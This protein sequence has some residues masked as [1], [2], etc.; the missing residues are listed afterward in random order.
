MVDRRIAR[1]DVA[2]GRGSPRFELA[3]SGILSHLRKPPRGTKP[4]R[5]PTRR[6]NRHVHASE[7]CGKLFLPINRFGKSQRCIRMNT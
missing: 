3:S 4:F 7:G 2:G 6:V 5:R 1:A